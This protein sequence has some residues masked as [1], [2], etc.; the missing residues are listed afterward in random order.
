MRSKENQE[1]YRAIFRASWYTGGS[2]VLSLLLGLGKNKVIALVIG[3]VGVGFAAMLQQLLSVL[4]ALST[5][6]IPAAAVR[7]VAISRD[8]PAELSLNIAASRRANRVLSLAVLLPALVLSGQLSILMFSTV[9]Y[10]T[11]VAV[12]AVTLYVV[13]IARTEHLILR[14]FGEVGLLARE[15]VLSSVIG[16]VATALA[17]WLWGLHGVAP[18]CLFTAA[19]QVVFARRA[20]RKICLNL[21]SPDPSRIKLRARKLG[22]TGI[23]FF[24]VTAIGIGLSMILSL[25]VRHAEGLAGNGIYQAAVS[26][27]VTIAGF[28]LSAMDQDFYPKLARM[29]AGE[30][31]LQASQYVSQQIHMGL[32]LAT[33]LLLAVSA[34]AHRLVELAYSRE[35]SQAGQLIPM[36]AVGSLAQITY[37]PMMLS[38]LAVA[39][40]RSLIF[41]E[42]AFSVV[43]IISAAVAI[44]GFG[45]PGV[46]IA[47]GT[48]FVAY[49]QGLAAI[50]RRRTGLSP[51][52]GLQRSYLMSILIMLVTAALPMPAKL[53]AIT[54]AVFVTM[55]RLTALLGPRH[56]LSRVVS[57]IPLINLFCR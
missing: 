28:I 10:L 49:S 12:I 34:F 21:P 46:A 47:Y 33:P 29:L 30:S 48:S 17:V 37:R 6:G 32:L 51:L 24:G 2:R 50:V 43:V 5:L 23:S 52:T 4:Q 14:A 18:S 7:A 26:L 22:A 36:L 15:S 19:L 9:E 44:R 13:Q 1:N 25:L 40:T 55:Y 11:D 27:T 8:D 42:L 20:T 54:L 38:L 53:T 57:A 3:A 39:E 31:Q 56:R 35:L 41:A 45:I 16:S